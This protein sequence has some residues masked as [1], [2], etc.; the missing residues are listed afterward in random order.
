[1]DR[2][3]VMIDRMPPDQQP[4]IV[5]PTPVEIGSVIEFGGEPDTPRRGRGPRFSIAA[6]GSSLAA[7]SRLVPLAAA[8]G[9]VAL[10]ASLISEWQ[11]TN[12]DATL[13]GDGQV[14]TKPLASTIA[15]LGGWGAGYLVGVFLLVAAAVLVLFGPAPGRRYARLLGLS[16]GGVLIGLLAAV[17]SEL[18]DT[19]RALNAVSNAS[20]TQDQI[21]LEYGRGLWC[22]LFGV[23]A[24]GLALILAGRHL[25]PPEEYV[26]VSTEH[27]DE[28][29]EVMPP[30]WSWRRTRS[31]AEELAERP[32]DEPFDLTVSA[33]R[34]FT[35][36]N[37]ERDKPN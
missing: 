5:E 7:D 1:V 23:A 4:S 24:T 36:A 14:G 8:L 33:V 35:P 21:Q 29:A 9:G 16:A 32:P 25:L 26:L 37:D 6:W 18:G 31:A 19:S 34:P 2:A 3:R 17:G 22:A 27:A 11:V 28:P 12:V 30:A 13:L 10:F 15:D 20:F